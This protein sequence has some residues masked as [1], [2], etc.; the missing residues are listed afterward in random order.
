MKARACKP[1]YEQWYELW[2]PGIGEVYER[3]PCEEIDGLVGDDAVILGF[4][5]ANLGGDLP[6]DKGIET[7]LHLAEDR[8]LAVTRSATASSSLGVNVLLM[9]L[10]RLVH[11]VASV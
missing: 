7:S 9:L 2:N 10:R 5:V 3:A 6:E 4:D 11:L 1:P 8:S